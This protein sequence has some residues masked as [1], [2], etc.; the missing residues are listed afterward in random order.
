ME[1]YNNG[2]PKNNTLRYLGEFCNSSKP[3]VTNML[4]RNNANKNLREDLP[5][6]TFQPLKTEEI[7]ISFNNTYDVE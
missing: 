2:V 3:Q 4:S 7:I 1:R 5:R 6:T